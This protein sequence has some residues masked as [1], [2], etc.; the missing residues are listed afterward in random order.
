MNIK[1]II[2][3]F[4]VLL[5]AFSFVMLVPFIIGVIY[6]EDN[7]Q[8]YIFVFIIVFA[9]GLFLWLLSRGSLKEIRITEGFVITILFW[10]VLGMIGS[11]PFV[12]SGITIVDSVFESISGVTT[13]GATVLTALE[14][15]PKSLLIYRQ[16]LQWIGGM[17]LIILVV[18]IMP[19]FGIGGSQ[20]FKMDAPGFDS[21]E[22]LTPTIRES[23][24]ALW[25]IYI[26]LT[27]LCLISYV[28]AG[29]DTFDAVSH[30]L[31]TV[32]IGGFSTYDQS[33][34]F[35]NNVYIEI[36]CIMFMLLSATSFSL[37]YYSIFHGKRLKH[38]YDPELRFF[39]LVILGIIIIISFYYL[40]INNLDLSSLRYIIFQTISIVTTSGFVTGEYSLM[41]GFVPFL[42]LVGAF[43]GACSGSVGGGLKAW[44]VLIIINQAK[45]E[46]TK[47]IHPSAVVTTKIGKKV[48][49]ASISEKVWGFFTVY[50]ITFIMLLMLVLSSGLDFES[51]FSAVG[52]TLNNLGPGLGAVSENYGSLSMMTK[53]TLCFAMILGRLEIF[54]LLVVL[55]PA[56]WRR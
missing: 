8:I 36:V 4:G 39:F 50:V 18:A 6:S 49:D 43:I 55:T 44:R 47:I 13:T 23:A 26:G 52:A 45:K 17:G 22:K 10:F 7:H 25:K 27:V 15:L 28:L 12:L 21:S 29:M 9:F 19:S 53:I 54:T 30:A 37:H 56:F 20:L 48:I 24:A 41:P 40:I 35:F 5:I 14:D 32:S 11:I 2:N 38:F 16:L 33:I 31:S 34:G 51:A 42:L 3:L 46:I 1:P